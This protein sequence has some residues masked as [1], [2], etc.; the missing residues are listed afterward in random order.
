MKIRRFYPRQ[1]LRALEGKAVQ[2]IDPGQ[3]KA[4]VYFMERSRKLNQDIYLLNAPISDFSGAINQESAAAIIANVT[5]KILLKMPA[6][7]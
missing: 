4:L 7:I 6:T 5:T 1:V 2:S 3:R